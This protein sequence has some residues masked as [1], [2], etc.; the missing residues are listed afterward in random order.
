[1]LRPRGAWATGHKGWY[2]VKCS[3]CAKK[4]YLGDDIVYW[5]PKCGPKYG[6]YYCRADA[7]RL[8]GKCPFCGTELVL[9]IQ[10]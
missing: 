7:K 9:V 6:I 2:E 3:I 10:I 1:M 8:H 4:L 5:C